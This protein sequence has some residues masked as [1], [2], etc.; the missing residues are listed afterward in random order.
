V[1]PPE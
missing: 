1:A